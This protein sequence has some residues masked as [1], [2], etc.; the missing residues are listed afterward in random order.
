MIEKNNISVSKCSFLQVHAVEGSHPGATGGQE[1]QGRQHPGTEEH[2]HATEEAVQPPLHLQ[3]LTLFY[4]RLP[5]LNIQFTVVCR[6]DVVS[7]WVYF[8]NK[9]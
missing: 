8:V 6:L 7:S 2:R 9:S 5:V 4:H 1:G 3:V